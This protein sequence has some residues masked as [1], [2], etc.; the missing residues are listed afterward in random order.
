MHITQFSSTQWKCWMVDI[1]CWTSTQW[2]LILPRAITQA[3]LG[4][5]YSLNPSLL[6]SQYNGNWLNFLDMIDW[7]SFVFT[8]RLW[9]VGN[10]FWNRWM[11]VFL[12]GNSGPGRSPCVHF[13]FFF[14]LCDQRLYMQTKICYN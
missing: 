12:C 11:K 2:V 6:F 10:R 3:V 14:E 9:W 13:L 5:Y 7:I 1:P 8:N 4:I